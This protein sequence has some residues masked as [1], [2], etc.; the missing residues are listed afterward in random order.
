IV[1]RPVHDTCRRPLVCPPGP[2]G[3]PPRH[4]CSTPCRGAG[5][6]VDDRLLLRAL[7]RELSVVQPDWS[8]CRTFVTSAGPSTVFPTAT[9]LS[10]IAPRVAVSALTPPGS[11][12]SPGHPLSAPAGGFDA[13]TGR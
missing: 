4:V 3:P 10:S 5:P 8:T 11:E 1:R 2:D 9:E 13:T 12:R 7:R 6:T